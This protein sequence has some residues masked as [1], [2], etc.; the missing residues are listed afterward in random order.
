MKIQFEA[1]Y[2]E[3]R[4]LLDRLKSK[5]PG[6]EMPILLDLIDGLDNSLQNED[7]RRYEAHQEALMETG[8]PDDSKYR[9]DLRDAGRGHLLR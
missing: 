9:Q 5:P 1:D 4:E 2:D 3:V 7:E 6:L 8:G